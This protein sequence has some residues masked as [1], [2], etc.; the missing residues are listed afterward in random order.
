MFVWYSGVLAA[1]LALVASP[2]LVAAPS[3]VVVVKW[4][5]GVAMRSAHRS[6][7]PPTRAHPAHPVH[8]AHPTHP[9]IH[10]LLFFNTYQRI[11]CALIYCHM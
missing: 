9:H 10:E 11:E 3:L 8:P 2:V 7:R 6:T 1:L 4:V 5:V